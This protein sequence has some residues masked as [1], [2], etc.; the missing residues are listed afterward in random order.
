VRFKSPPYL[1]RVIKKPKT[2]DETKE[3]EEKKK[4]ITS[5]E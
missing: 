4:K 5:K 3:E 1:Y 2:K